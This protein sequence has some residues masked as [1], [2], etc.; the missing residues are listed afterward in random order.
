MKE[1]ERFDQAHDVLK[2]WVKVNE[3]QKPRWFACR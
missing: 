1:T 2:T 3:Q